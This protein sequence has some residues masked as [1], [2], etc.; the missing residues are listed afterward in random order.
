MR[1]DRLVAIVLL[2]QARG[3]M[4]APVLAEELEVSTR[5]VYR[6]VDALS[7]AGVPVY[8]ERGARGGIRLLEGYRTDLTGLNAG[9][10][11][12]LLLMGIPGPVGQLGLGAHTDAARRKVMAALPLSGRTAAEAVRHK[13]YVDPE[14]W[15]EVPLLEHLVPVANAVWAERRIRLDYV[16]A[17]NEQVTRTVDPL[18]LV[19]K[20]GTWY[21]IAGMGSWEVTFRVERI[22]GVHLLDRAAHRPAGW[23]LV[24]HWRTVVAEI[25][26]E[27]HPITASL[28]VDRGAAGE[29]TQ[30]LGE[31]VRDQVVAGLQGDGTQLRIVASFTSERAAVSAVLG[32]G[33]S[34]EVLAPASL[35]NLVGQEVT[36]LHGRYATAATADASLAH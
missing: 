5:T 35:R 23:D 9:E 8:A 32:L 24:A 6:D 31:S 30:R 28:L 14:G 17:D 7:A 20:A 36:A 16:R 33:A 21:L 19:L 25:H 18:G 29:L 22:R 15:T 11:E 13:V 4:S 3:P 1:A 12:A 2:L 10:A 26:Q 27:D 34:T